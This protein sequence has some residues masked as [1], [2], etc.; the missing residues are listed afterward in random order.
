MATIDQLARMIEHVSTLA[1]DM[2]HMIGNAD[3]TE[4]FL[5]NLMANIGGNIC[6]E[7]WQAI[8]AASHKPCNKQGCECHKFREAVIAGMDVA[9]AAWRKE[10]VDGPAFR[11]R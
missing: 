10:M 8:V 4:E 1:L 5:T 9:R 2:T 7:H 6:D 3:Q 11:F